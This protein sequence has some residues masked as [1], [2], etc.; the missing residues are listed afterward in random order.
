RSI[1]GSNASYLRTGTA[2]FQSASDR[3]RAKRCS[4]PNSLST[5][6]PTMRRKRISSCAAWGS[7]RAARKASAFCEANMASFRR[8]G[9][10][11]GGPA[12]DAV[13]PVA[14]GG[15]ELDGRVELKAVIA[16]ERDEGDGRR[17]ARERGP[18]GVV[19]GG[20][21]AA[22]EHAQDRARDAWEPTRRGDG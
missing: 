6:G 13:H 21:I 18:G 5:L 7:A 17:D 9:R 22:G 11:S 1:Q 4:R 16:L 15:R 10:S 19:V 20:A 2:L 12:H 14:H 8:G 3:M